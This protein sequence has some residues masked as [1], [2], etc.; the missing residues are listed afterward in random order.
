MLIQLSISKKKPAP[1][2]PAP[3]SYTHSYHNNNNVYTVGETSDV[4]NENYWKKATERDAIIKQ[5]VKEAEFKV[6]DVCV[7]KSTAEY[8]KYGELTVQAICDSYSKFG[9]YEE[10]PDNDNPLL[11][12]CISSKTQ[13]VVWTTVNYLKKK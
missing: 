9:V 2:A 1:P 8:N 6:G 3:V 10:W 13:G 5:L 7:P 12:S 11:V 4:A